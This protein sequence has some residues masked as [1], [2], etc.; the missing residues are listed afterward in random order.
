ML[1]LHS[2]EFVQSAAGARQRS[3]HK[4]VRG[5]GGVEDE[6]SVGEGVQGTVA[7]QVISSGHDLDIGKEN[8]PQRLL[9]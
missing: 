9:P 2:L 8:K 5:R 7:L 3:Q 6:G 4:R 1:T